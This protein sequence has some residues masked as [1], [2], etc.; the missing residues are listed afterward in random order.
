ME[1]IC[2]SVLC[3]KIPKTGT[4]WSTKLRGNKVIVSAEWTVEDEI[5][6][7]IYNGTD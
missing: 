6:A 5:A 4:H 1:M 3:F 2:V 7:G